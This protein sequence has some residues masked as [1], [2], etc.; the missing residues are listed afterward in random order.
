L[1]PIYENEKF[2]IYYG[3]PKVMFDTSFWSRDSRAEKRDDRLWSTRIRQIARRLLS[4]LKRNCKR[5]KIFCSLALLT[6]PKAC[7]PI[8]LF[9]RWWWFGLY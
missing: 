3:F 4:L 6:T 5:S 2:V 7:R 1:T 8:T 9:S